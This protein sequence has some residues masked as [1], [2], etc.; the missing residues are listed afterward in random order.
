MMITK[1]IA[2]E[3]NRISVSNLMNDPRS[4]RALSTRDFIINDI[5][6]LVEVM[7]IKEID[8]WNDIPF[9]EIKTIKDQTPTTTEEL[10]VLLNVLENKA[11]E[12]RYQFL[13]EEYYIK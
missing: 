2:H 9:K 4:K 7:N 1:D 13:M 5:I 11:E 3:G 10:S 8:G 12:R 6:Q